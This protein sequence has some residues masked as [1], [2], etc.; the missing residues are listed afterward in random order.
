MKIKDNFVLRQVAGSYVVVAVGAASVDFNG[1]LMLNESG[2]LLWHTLE[3]GAD[4]AALVAALTSEYEVDEAQGMITISGENFTP[5]SIVTVNGTQKD[6]TYVD[7]HTLII[8][9][10]LLSA[11]A[12]AVTVRQVTDRGE[13]LSESDTYFIEE[14]IP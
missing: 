8:Q 3:R 13:V 11:L 10:E 6:T 9:P 4:R 14:V 12:R 7:E 1:M 2:A 5:Y